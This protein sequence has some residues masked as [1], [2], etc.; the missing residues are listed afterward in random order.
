[1]LPAGVSFLVGVSCSGWLDWE[2]IYRNNLIFM[3][4]E[5]EVDGVFHITY[6]SDIFLIKLRSN[7]SCFDIV[8]DICHVWKPT[9]GR[10]QSLFDM[11]VGVFGHF[12]FQPGEVYVGEHAVR[13]IACIV[14]GKLEA[15][16]SMEFQGPEEGNTHLEMK[17]IFVISRSKCI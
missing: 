14:K 11:S 9:Q 13:G 3:S 4:D 7:N 8:F 5:M 6:R 12:D 1:M 10:R 17:R 2:E 16:T 15:S